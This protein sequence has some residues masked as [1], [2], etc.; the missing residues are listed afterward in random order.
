MSSIFSCAKGGRRAV[1]IISNRKRIAA[2]NFARGVELLS[3]SGDRVLLGPS[4]DGG[5]YAI[6]LKKPHRQLFEQSDWST[7]RVLNQT[8][9]RANESGLEVKLLATG[10]DIDDDASLLRLCNELLANTTPADIAPHT[11]DFLAHL[12]AQKEL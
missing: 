6:G 8:I 2:E 10:Y 11:R 3:A 12:T 9:Q 4:D 7:E 1:W 5:Y